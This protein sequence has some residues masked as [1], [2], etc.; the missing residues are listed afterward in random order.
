MFPFYF[1]TLICLVPSAMAMKGSNSEVLKLK[2]I[3]QSKSIK[4]MFNLSSIEV[5]PRSIPT[6][7]LETYMSTVII[8]KYIIHLFIS[9][10]VMLN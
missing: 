5:L 3:P 10:I 9:Q 1:I 7:N 2:N 4:E 8:H 6:D